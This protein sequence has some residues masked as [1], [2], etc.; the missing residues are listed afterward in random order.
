MHWAEFR[1]ESD[2]AAAWRRR[3]QEVIPIYS[4]FRTWQGIV[5]LDYFVNPYFPRGSTSLAM[6][7]VLVLNI[8]Q[9]FVPSSLSANYQQAFIDLQ[10]GQFDSYWRQYGAWLSTRQLPPTAGTI[11]GWEF[12]GNWFPYNGNGLLPAQWQ[13]CFRRCVEQTRIGYQQATPPA[14][15][16]R[17]QLSFGM[18][19][20]HGSSPGLPAGYRAIDYF[21]GTQWC[22]TWGLNIYDRWNPSYTEVDWIANRRKANSLDEHL[23]FVRSVPGLLFNVPEWGVWN[24]AY[25]PSHPTGTLRGSNFLTSVTGG[26]RAGMYYCSF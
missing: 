12:N 13:S 15:V 19:T 24:R 7:S 4:D 10:N 1:A 6:P 18:C 2:R 25:D 3:P 8:F 26:E 16:T 23:A 14:G 22:D 21:P 20:S 11:F 9:P 5:N 17:S